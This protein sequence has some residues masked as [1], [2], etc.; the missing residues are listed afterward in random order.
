MSFKAHLLVICLIIIGVYFAWGSMNVPK[1]PEKVVVIDAP[2]TITLTHATW[3]LN[4]H[5]VLSTIAK[6]S[7][8]YADSDKN[9]KSGPDNILKQVATLC[10]G[11]QACDIIADVNT[12]GPDPFPE[13]TPKSLDIEYRCFSYDRPRIISTTA[14]NA[15]L[16]CANDAADGKPVATPQPSPAAAPR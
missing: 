15:S 10:D 1:A 2:N 11:K 13:C 9:N 14:G 3:G 4:C 12:L 16:R 5:K 7:D 8:P 6:P